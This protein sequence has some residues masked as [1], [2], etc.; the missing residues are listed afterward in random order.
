MRTDGGT[1]FMNKILKAYCE[2]HGLIYQHS[3]VESQEE[4][5]S[6]ER[7][8]QTAMGNVQCALLGSGMAAKWWPEALMYLTE[9]SNRLP[10][11][12]LNGKNP[13]EALFGKKP[14]GKMLRIWGSTCYAHVPK[15]KRSNPKFSNRAIEC[16]LLGLSTNY[17]GYR[18]LDIKGNQYLTARDVKFGDTTTASLITR[19]FPPE[20]LNLSEEE[21]HEVYTLGKRKRETGTQS[22]GSETKPRK[23]STKPTES[24]S[25]EVVGDSSPRVSAY[26]VCAFAQVSS[27]TWV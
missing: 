19:S 4:N 21:L 13:H 12:R 6:A 14:S 17:K 3:N 24:T 27:A 2:K 8:H 25:P 20:V 5:G 11:A 26:M 15:T 10:T 9:V 18:L 7:A 22:I 23:P 16:K 1:E